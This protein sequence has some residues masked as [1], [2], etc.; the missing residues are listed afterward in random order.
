MKRRVFGLIALLVA[1]L[2]VAGVPCGV[3]AAEYLLVYTGTGA[4]ADGTYLYVA[5]F[6]LVTVR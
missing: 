6:L 2:L 5:M 3:M 1:V 4:I